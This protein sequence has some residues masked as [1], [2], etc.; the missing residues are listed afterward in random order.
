MNKNDWETNRV[1]LESIIEDVVN[2]E[3][4]SQYYQNIMNELQNIVNYHAKN[5]LTITNF[6]ELNKS[7]LSSMY[8]LIS[9]IKDSG[10]KQEIHKIITPIENRG[11]KHNENY[12]KEQISNER[13]NA[14]NTK[15]KNI[16]KEYSDTFTNK[17]KTI[18]FSD[19]QDEP[20]K[21][22]DDLMEKELMKRKYDIQILDDNTKKQAEEWL[23]NGNTTMSSSKLNKDLHNSLED[24]KVN[25]ERKI[26][27]FSDNKENQKQKLKSILKNVS[28]N[29]KV[30][31]I[32]E[33]QQQSV[34]SKQT[35]E[36]NA[37]TKDI[38]ILKKKINYV[39]L[40][41]NYKIVKTLPFL[42]SSLFI[43]LYDEEQ[44][45]VKITDNSGIEHITRCFIDKNMSTEK[46]YYIKLIEALH[47][48][49]ITH[50]QIQLLNTKKDVLNISL[51]NQEPT[52]FNIKKILNKNIQYTY[53]TLPCDIV[54]T[55]ESIVL[56]LEN[57]NE[58]DFTTSNAYDLYIDDVKIN[59]FLPVEI[60]KIERKENT[61]VVNIENMYSK[62]NFNGI[63]IDKKYLKNVE[64]NSKIKI[65][66]HEIFEGICV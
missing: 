23:K 46:L 12:T 6:D 43:S 27:I 10:V 63:I 42:N 13:L 54:N 37:N 36:R 65:I 22:I 11:S 44:M 30:E 40:N 50:L 16:E 64:E 14:F 26:K 9:S 2:E 55:D 24:N 41:K 29:N 52:C 17:P 59:G 21:D 33:M 51:C 35:I 60:G 58:Y 61:H 34:N 49:N 25:V 15:L 47:I 31:N 18:D 53:L 7:I 57:E 4:L 38:V 8:E 5:R 45:Y 56:I 20:V 32:T 62:D 1:L 66:E 28:F 39:V 3:N 19:T 48:E